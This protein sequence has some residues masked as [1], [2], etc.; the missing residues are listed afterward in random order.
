ML[1]K[2][3]GFGIVGIIATAIDFASLFLLKSV[4]GVD[5]Y[6]ATTIAFSLSL[7]FN[8]I[9]SMKYVFVAKEGL[10]VKK[11]MVIFLVTSVIGLLI[12]QAVMYVGIEWLHVYYMLAKFLATAVTMVFNFVARHLL[13]EK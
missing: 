1:N 3:I 2:I 8:Y 6:I 4:L 9:A 12:N 11:Q 13:L 7:I 10:S 5:V